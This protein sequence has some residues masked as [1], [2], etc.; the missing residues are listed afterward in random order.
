[1]NRT[2]ISIAARFMAWLAP[3]ALAL[4]ACNLEKEITI[5]LPEYNAR[6]SVEC[7]LEAG[8]PFFLLMTKTVPYF[9][10]F[11]TLDDRFLQNIL[12]DSA[13]VVIRHN[14]QEYPLQNRLSFNPF[15]GK[16]YNYFSAVPVPE[17]YEHDFELS[18]V[19]KTG[20]TI[21]AT[22]RLLPRVPIDSVVVQFAPNDTLARVLTYFTDD[23]SQTNYY[24]RMLHKSTLDSIPLQDF[25][26]DDSFSETARFVFGTNYEFAE[27]DTIINTLFHISRAYNDY[28]DSVQTAFFSNGNPF[29]QPSPIQ[30]NV[31]GTANAIG[32]FTGL[33]YDRVTTIVRR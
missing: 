31:R 10:D 23:R 24:R 18:V 33:S 22:T 12:E 27:G 7:Y 9:E 2:H 4:S 13:T 17:D 32:I 5:E 26:V 28:F 16:L 14:G 29:G 19:T 21:T 1:M 3:L 25:T 8:K 15:T 20:K 6:P 30:S 11:P